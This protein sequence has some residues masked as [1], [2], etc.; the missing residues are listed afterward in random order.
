MA[1]CS[2]EEQQSKRDVQEAPNFIRWKLPR[3]AYL[4]VDF[5]DARC[6][7]QEEV[8]ETRT[9]HSRHVGRCDNPFQI[10]EQVVKCGS[11]CEAVDHDRSGLLRACSIHDG[12]RPF[13][14]QLI[15]TVI[16]SQSLAKEALAQ[17][18]SVEVELTQDQ[19]RSLPLQPCPL[20]SLMLCLTW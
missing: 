5:A 7:A 16:V 15:V 10:F 19:L 6:P 9:R 8:E 12:E 2:D 3:E 18:E 14:K 17:L 4:C 1:A 11:Q 13:G 20:I